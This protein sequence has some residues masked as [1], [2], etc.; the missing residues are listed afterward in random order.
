MSNV[1][2]IRIRVW[3]LL[4]VLLQYTVDPLDLE[5][6]KSAQLRARAPI[7]RREITIP[8]PPRWD[9]LPTTKGGTNRRSL[10]VAYAAPN[11]FFMSTCG[12]L[13]KGR[14][15]LFLRGA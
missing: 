14:A 10:D 13:R 6:C 12:E 1:P 3:G 7:V 9:H 4:P 8:S 11:L 15:I 2:E 5:G